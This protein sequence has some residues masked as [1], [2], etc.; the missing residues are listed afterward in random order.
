MYWYYVPYELLCAKCR[1]LFRIA[2]S[3]AV[4]AAAVTSLLL[5]CFQLS[6]TNM[7]VCAY[8]LFWIKICH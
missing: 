4:A 6:G 3:V 7:F 1:V 8:T 5:A 2:A